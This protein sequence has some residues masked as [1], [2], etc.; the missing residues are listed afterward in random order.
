VYEPDGRL[1]FLV[2]A[3]TCAHTIRDG[4]EVLFALFQF[5][6]LAF[7]L[8]LVCVSGVGLVELR[9]QRR[10]RA[11][12]QSA[13]LACICGYSCLTALYYSLDPVRGRRLLSG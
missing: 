6:T 5:A 10:L 8:A 12:L 2:D 7:L 11:N 3:P 1:W 13:A 4:N 9:R